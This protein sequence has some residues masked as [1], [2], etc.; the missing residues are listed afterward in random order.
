MELH[1]EV[2]SSSSIKRKKPW[3]RFCWLGKE[4]EAVFLLDDKRISE[5]NMVSGR[6]KKKIPK[7]QPFLNQVVTMASSHNG[8][9]LCG[10][11]VSGELFL[12]NRDK[13][14]LKTAS[15]VPEILNLVAAVQENATRL[16]VQA[17]GDGLRVLVVSITGQVFLWECVSFKDLT[18]IRDG[19]VKGRWSHICA[20]ED[21]IL[22]SE[23]D[24]EASQHTIFVKT[25]DM[26]DACLSAFV[27]TAGMKLIIT[28]LKI[29]WEE[30]PARVGSEG[31]NIEWVTK[32]YSLPCLTP[33]C[34]PVRSR[35]ALVPAFSPDGRL[36]AVVLN[37]REPK[38]TQVLFVSMQNFVS[39]SSGLGGCGSKKLE[40]PSKYIRS[41]WVGSVC[42]SSDSLFLACVLKRGS[43]LMVS[44]LTGLLTLSSSG[45]SVDFGPS[46]FLPLHPLVTYRPHLLP[47]K[48]E[49]SLSSSGR[50]LRDVF[51]QRY[52][53]TWHPRLLYLIVSD[54]YMA[55]VIR[56]LGKPSAAFLLKGLIKNT[57]ED[58]EKA[59]G[60][61]EKSQER[62]LEE[63]NPKTIDSVIST[64]TEGS[65]LPLFL[66]DQGTL[67][68]PKELLEKVQV[69][70]IIEN[71]FFEDDSDADGP[72]AGSH[73]E[74]GGRLE[75][76]SMFDTVHAQDFEK[77]CISTERKTP[78]LHRKLGKIQSKLLTAW[79]FAMSL[80]TAVE[81][82]TLLLKHNLCCMLRFAA[83]LQLIPSSVVHAGKKKIS[84][85]VC[86]LRLLRALLAFL[87]WD[88]IHAGG[89]QCLGL[90]VSFTQQ[91]VR[92]LLTPTPTS[93][94]AGQCPLSSRALSTV[95]LILQQVSD[96]LDHAYSLQRRTVWVS[97]GKDPQP[98]LCPSDIYHVPQLQ[99]SEDEKSSFTHRTQPLPQRPSSRL[100]GVWQWVYRIT[101]EYMEEVKNFKDC[102]GWEEEQHQ[103]RL[104]MSQ[105]QAAI[106]ATGVKLEEGPA[107]LSYPV[108]GE[109]FYLFGS[110]FKSDKAWRSQ[111]CKENLKLGCDRRVFKETQLCLALLYSLLSQYRLREA[112][113]F[114][115]HM[116]R[117]VLHKAGHQVADSFPCPWVP[118]DLHSDAACSVVQ[119]LGRFMASYFTN[120]PLYIRPPHHVGLLPPLHLPH[121]LSV[122][123]L[124]PL[125]QEEVSRAVRLQQLSEVWTVD[126]ARDLLLLGGLLPEAVWLAYHLGDWKSAVSLSLAYTNYCSDKPDFTLLKR[127]ELH[128][129]V[130][131]EAKTIF[132]LEL[133]CLLSSRSE[134][135]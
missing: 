100:L 92:L 48:G 93:Q 60:I 134:S 119:N 14:L 72:P 131:L 87:P 76:A 42:W 109:H 43:L 8:L 111:I 27:F 80:G 40:I 106:Q 127:R 4:R 107:L 52:S 44:R 85:H 129:P 56:V 65:S 30:A 10:L 5:I 110:Y 95:L 1:L 126:Y 11:M 98:H 115:D 23:Q 75:F 68:A 117:L 55:T 58:L 6:T 132:Q 22:P 36:F 15:A 16:S 122:G 73:L 21:S 20:L 63:F 125:S 89:P 3:P 31:Y 82:R 88:G 108:S 74:D 19:A 130:D 103:L 97:A 114:G 46:Q 12:W 99:D 33:P 133:E 18:A 47:G 64:I 34:K 81:N 2:V 37:Q 86:L 57:T 116:A 50:S 45:C 41:Y 118:V 102:D 112:Q 120:Q 62:G 32:T 71:T 104:I 84:V 79:A 25:K 67:N 123:R 124:V 94:Q 49:A 38:A 69:S 26:G 77:E 96:A 101:Q 91:L 113:E 7:I 39:V 53:V 17:S 24:K 83:L 121:A 9:W 90:V 61:L 66:Q 70:K 54:G 59:S 128:L 105:I 135:Q 29:V 28:C 78:G 13:D 51:R 35:G